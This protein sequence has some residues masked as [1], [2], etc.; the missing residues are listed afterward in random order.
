MGSNIERQ[1]VPLFQPEKCIAGTGLEGQVALDSGSVLDAVNITSSVNGDTVRTESVI[2]QRS[3][4]NTCTHKKPQIRQGECVKKGQILGDGATTVGGHSNRA[5][6]R[7][8]SID[9]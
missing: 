8:Q 6:A 5:I 3:N 2:Y 7:Y 4:T 9:F 1:A